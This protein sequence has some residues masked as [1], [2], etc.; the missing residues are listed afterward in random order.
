DPLRPPASLLNRV[1]VVVAVPLVCGD[2]TVRPAD[3]DITQVGQPVMKW[4]PATGATIQKILPG[5]MVPAGAIAV[6]FS[7][8][9]LRQGEIVKVSYAAP[10]CSG[11]AKTESFSVVTAGATVLQRPTLDMP[12]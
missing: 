8:T 7:D 12:P 9:V 10:V 6:Q 5:V 2:R 11:S 3:V 4:L 1:L